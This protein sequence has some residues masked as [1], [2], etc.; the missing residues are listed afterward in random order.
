MKL[1]KMISIF[2]ASIVASLLLASP[3]QATLILTL[4]DGENTQTITDVGDN[5]AVLFVGSVGQWILN[6]TLGVS[7][8]LIGDSNKARLDLSSLNVMGLSNSGGSLTISL[9]N[10]DV[11]V[12]HGDTNFSVDLGGTTDGQ[13]SFQSYID[14]TNTAFGTETLLY[15]TGVLTGGSFSSTVYGGAS[16]TG[17]YSIT[18]VATIYHEHGLSLTG[19]NHGVEIPEPAGLALLGIGLLGLGF[20][21]RRRRSRLS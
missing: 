5:G 9:T 11:S 12:P 7:D 15:D 18:T 6:V 2:G 20:V 1:K 19:F 14:S 3:A 21:I 8:P 4:S 16:V 10:T 17:P 13:I